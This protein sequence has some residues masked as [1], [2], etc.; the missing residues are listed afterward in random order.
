MRLAFSVLVDAQRISDRPAGAR[1]WFWCS[2]CQSRRAAVYLAPRARVYRCR[3]CAQ[4]GYL[5]KFAGPTGA[6]D[7]ACVRAALRLGLDYLGEHFAYGGWVPRPKG[8][9]RATYARLVRQFGDANA[10]RDAL[11]LSG[12][13]RTL[14]RVDPGWRGRG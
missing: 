4:L 9:R 14:D 6:A 11:F 2:G 3:V 5:S 10:R 13:A 7:R 12:A 1:W 8:M